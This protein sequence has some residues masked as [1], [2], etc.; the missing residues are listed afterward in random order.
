ML[1]YVTKEK[2][3]GFERARIKH[4]P[5][6]VAQRLT[7]KYCCPYAL[8]FQKQTRAFKKGNND[9]R[10]AYRYFCNPCVYVSLTMEKRLVVISKFNQIES[11]RYSNVRNP[12]NDS[13]LLVNEHK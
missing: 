13:R 9:K 5:F 7:R 2:N 6:D 8:Y 12:C 4:K 11:S 10:K 1:F 3:T